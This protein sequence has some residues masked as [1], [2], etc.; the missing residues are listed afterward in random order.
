MKALITLLIVSLSISTAEAAQTRKKPRPRPP[1]ETAASPQPGP[2]ILGSQVTLVTKN[3]DRIT[4]VILDLT[5]YSI[6]IRANN[7]ES[8]IALDTLAS[9]SFGT[10]TPPV[11]RPEQPPVRPEFSRDSTAV[12]T[13]IQTMVTQTNAGIDYTDYGRQLSDLRRDVEQFIGGYSSSEN[14]LETRVVALVAGALTDYNWARTVWNL[15]IGR[16]S[17][18]SVNEAEISNL[19][20]LYPDLRTSAANGNKLSGDKMIASLWRK[21]AQK[22]DRARA[23]VAQPR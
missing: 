20:A 22:S 2:R 4:G 1:R 14:P 12:L 5:A 8:I 10:A 21:A 13:S 18:G 16:T 17:D 3:G 11:Q 23:L 9:M 15:K 6:R 7:L 19:L